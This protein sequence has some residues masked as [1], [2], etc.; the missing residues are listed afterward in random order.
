MKKIEAIIGTPHLFNISFYQ[1]ELPVE[2]F[3]IFQTVFCATAAT[4]VSGGMAERSKFAM[5]LAYTVLISVLIYPVS[6]HRTWGDGLQQL[7]ECPF[8]PSC[9]HRL[10]TF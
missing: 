5:Y 1:T 8:P 2:G 3:L 7:V 9:Q 4:I 6:G 10:S